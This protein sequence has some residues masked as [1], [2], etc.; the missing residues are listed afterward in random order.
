MT[1]LS[2]E[3]EVLELGRKIQTEAQT[4]MEKFNANIISVN[5]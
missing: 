2:K 1:I 3:L 4:E 5:N